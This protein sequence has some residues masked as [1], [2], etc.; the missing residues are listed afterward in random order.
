MQQFIDAGWYTVPLKGKLE[1]LKDSE[2]KTIPIFEKDWKAKYKATK[3]TKATAIGGVITGPESNIIAIDCDNGDTYD[4]F[5]ALDPDYKAVFISDG[6]RGGTFIYLYEASVSTFSPTDGSLKL[7]IYSDNGFVYLPTSANKSKHTWTDMP[8]IQPMPA[9]TRLVLQQLQKKIS[10]ITEDDK[11]I[12]SEQTRPCLAP[13]L[14][15]FVGKRG[16]FIPSLF[17]II[18]PK[19]FRQEEQYQKFGYLHPNNV[20][21]GRGSEYLSKLSAILGADESVDQE[22]YMDCMTQFNALFNEPMDSSRMDATICDPML[23]Q[24][25]SI[26]GKVIWAYNEFWSEKRMTVLTKHGLI[27]DLAFD[28]A[29]NM[30]YFIDMTN[31]KLRSFGKD[32][33]FISYIE[34]TVTTEMP[35]KSILKRQIPLIRMLSDPSQLFGFCKGNEPQIL[36]FN[37]FKPS[38]ALSIMHNPQDYAKF[39]KLPIQTLKYLECLVP[40]T[41]ARNYLLQFIKRKLTRFEYSPVILFF[42][43]VPGSG[44]DTFVKILDIIMGGVTRPTVEMFLE[45]YNTWLLDTYFVQL[46]EYGDQLNKIAD[47]EMAKGLLKAYT[48]KAE[49]EIRDMRTKGMPYK[50]S[51]TFILTANKNPLMI[52]DQDRRIHLMDTPN[53]L[54]MQPWF[55]ADVYDEIMAEVPDF[56]YYLATQ[57]KELSKDCYMSPPKSADKNKLIADS[58]YAAQRIAYALE[59]DMRDYLIE[60]A[61]DHNCAD[62]A[63]G[64][65]KGVFTRTALENLYDELTD[66]KGDSKT[67]NKILRK[68]G[69]NGV[70]KTIS[71]GRE[72][73]YYLKDNNPFGDDDE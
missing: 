36:S 40:N 62:F 5:S 43:G 44:K 73:M 50:H 42:L 13:L 61:T 26:D 54:E 35:K 9:T 68:K 33:D 12:H 15:Q 32:T 59:H 70:P 7:D 69:F 46:D 14:T 49:V 67:I 60:L 22:L 72:Y 23:E 52:D 20:P 8:S 2:D 31:E 57:V 39:Y 51:A 3:N 27:V 65:A 37:S 48:G 17:K 63:G 56:C 16:E 45:K 11:Y 6:K 38:A 10:P 55:T 1:R 29:R 4:L 53:V 58:M 47:K 19:A 25:A 18:T 64:I 66:F 21:D 30:Y 34:V 24:K 41:E 71:S 28:D